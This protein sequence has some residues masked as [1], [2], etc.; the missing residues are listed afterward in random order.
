[1]QPAAQAELSWRQIERA[2]S[3]LRHLLANGLSSFLLAMGLALLKFP[4]H[5]FGRKL[6][7][8]CL[9]LRMALGV[10]AI[11]PTHAFWQRDPGVHVS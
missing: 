7:E 10:F 5:L 6:C 11:P 2:G 8:L 3:D 9:Q 4:E 1:M